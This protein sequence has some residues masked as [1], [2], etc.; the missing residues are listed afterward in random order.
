MKAIFS[1]P[2]RFGVALLFVLGAC[3]EAELIEAP[4][5][6]EPTRESIGYY[7]NMIV[8]DHPGPKGQ[9][10]VGSDK[11]PIWFS[12]VRD[13]IAFMRLP[14]EPKNIQGVYVNDM[15]KAQTWDQPEPE[16]WIS[17][18][19]AF[20]VI[21]SSRRG[22]MGAK[23]AVPFGTEAAA[24]AFAQEHGGRVETLA[25]VPDEYI[26]AAENGPT[27]SGSDH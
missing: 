11:E 15:G 4:S 20:Y 9:I 26:L 5:P 7:C 18:H 6:Q 10:F 13:T 21:H 3:D 25:D 19:D 23:E 24:L 14:E 17:A 1:R 27:H 22:G 8:P 2:V 16:T 12:S